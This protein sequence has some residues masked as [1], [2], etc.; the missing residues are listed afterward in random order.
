[1]SYNLKIYYFFI[2]LI[3]HFA[4]KASPV[5]DTRGVKYDSSHIE[6]LSFDQN[7]LAQYRNDKD[8][9]YSEFV[10][11]NT[12]FSKIKKS[13]FNLLLRFFEWIFGHTHALDKLQ[14]FL[15]VFPYI[16]IALIVFLLLKIFLKIKFRNLLSG[17]PPNTEVIYN[18]DE[19]IIRKEDIDNLIEKSINEGD[20]RLA[21]RYYY[22]KLLK[23]LD[24]NRIIHWEPQKTN[25]E[26]L[27]EVKNPSIKPNFKQFTFWYDYIWYGNYS[28]KA[29]EFR[30]IFEAFQLFFKKIRNSND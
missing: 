6:I 13:V 12:F 3:A 23:L 20:F 21:I 27:N 10:N 25:Y 1:M 15:R 8:F 14:K 16:I 19:E 28:L 24:Q 30:D 4:V 7:D 5:I 2:L 26:Y 9:D 22:L 18:N 29:E 11:K 17:S